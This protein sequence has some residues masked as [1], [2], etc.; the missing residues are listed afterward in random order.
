MEAFIETETTCWGQQQPFFFKKE[1]KGMTLHYSSAEQSSDERK[2]L[3]WVQMKLKPDFKKML[4]KLGCLPIT[5]LEE[6][7]EIQLDNVDLEGELEFEKYLKKESAHADMLEVK[8]QIEKKKQSSYSDHPDFQKYLAERNSMPG[9]RLS[10]RNGK[11]S[12]R[13]RQG[14]ISQAIDEQVVTLQENNTLKEEVSAMQS[15]LQELR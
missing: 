8:H 5:N 6:I 3:T 4:K 15:E 7:V 9:N 13:H 14:A 2:Y 1:E 12:I 11:Q 10:I